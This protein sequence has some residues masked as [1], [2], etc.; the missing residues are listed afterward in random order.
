MPAKGMH[1]AARLAR[2]ARVTVRKAPP[3]LIALALLAG[4]GERASGPLK[5]T[6][7]GPQ[8]TLINP[9]LQPV[10]PPAA[11]LLETVAQGLVRFDAAGEIEPALAQSWIVSDDGR[12]FT[13]RLRRALWARGERV[14]AEQV[15]AR[16]Q[17]ALSRASR[18]RLKSVL[19]VVEDVEAM[20]DQVLEIRLA[21]PRANFLELLAQPE[22]A[23]IASNEG[24]GPYR[25]GGRIGEALRLVPPPPEDDEAPQD[26]AAV[27]IRLAGATPALAVARFREGEADFVT[28]GTAGDLPI[29]RAAEI[30]QGQI[31]FDPTVGLFG[32]AFQSARGPLA[33]PAVRRALSMAIDRAAIL[34]R[35]QVPDWR[36]R[37]GLLPPGLDEVPAPAAPDWANLAYPQRRELAAL[38]IAGLDGDTPLRLRIAMPDRPGYRILFAHLR[39]DWRLIGVEVERVAANEAAELRLI[40]EVAPARLASWYLRPFMCPAS[41]VCDQEVTGLLE[42]ARATPN[43]AERRAVLA[44]ADQALTN[45][46]VFIPIAS[47]V[48]WSLRTQRLTGFRTNMFARHA[49]FELIQA[50][51]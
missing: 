43:P 41:P 27:E 32:L 2:F 30:P 16:L 45:A 9:N 5:V 31:A 15:V 19:G 29:L 7:I 42:S 20:T 11:M 21:N 18:N 12:R 35:F 6:A 38:A 37:T 14:T 47:P 3:L 17:A 22:M 44:Q 23:I 26:E 50:R 40:D 48:R 28:G 13:F 46:S 8:P 49:P 10:A 34:E 39:R 25:M 33:D 36:P 1:S 51:D 24:T 4:C